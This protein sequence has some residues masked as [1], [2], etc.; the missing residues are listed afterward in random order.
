MVR[1]RHLRTLRQAVITAAVGLAFTSLTFAL[2]AAALERALA[3]P[4]EWKSS[5]FIQAW[6][7]DAS[8]ALAPVSRA[9]LPD[10]ITLF[11][12]RAD[13]VA[14]RFLASGEVHSISI[15]ALDAG[16]FFGFNNTNLRASETF[17]AAKARFDAEFSS[18]KQQ[19]QDGLR[20]LGAQSQGE[21][22]L[23]ERSG[24]KL[25]AQLWK[26]GGVVARVISQEHQLLQADFFRS[27]PETRTL[28]ARPIAAA[29][30]PR[31]ASPL[32]SLQS[33]STSTATA[34]GPE[35][36]IASLPML[37][38]GN[39]AYCGV[40]I[41]AMVAHH[42]GLTLGAE[43]LAVANGFQYGIDGNPDIREMFSQVAREG[44]MKAQRAPRLD[45]NLMKR[46]LDAGM[47]VVVFRRWSQERDYLHSMY[48][49]RLARGEKA[50]LP[51]PG[52]EDRKSWPGK[53]APAHASIINGYRDDRREAVFTESWGPQARNRRMRF[54][55]LEAT[56]YYAIY[57]SK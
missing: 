31:H 22:N 21:L 25:R 19:L 33:R 29:P 5:A 51:V 49:A 38:Q 9:I 11:G 6:Q 54:E 46:A 15:V 20:K 28:L 42:I 32:A 17:E 37:A 18:R 8:D 57:F 48:S 27:E 26:G 12:F 2:D 1:L 56:S 43:E 34:A 44:G 50:E 47:P 3:A 23:G 24:L 39:R 53:D 35:R 40:A 45:V 4:S 14:A 7:R 41:L 13:T 55:E 52:I 36:R 10:E 16:N 30:E